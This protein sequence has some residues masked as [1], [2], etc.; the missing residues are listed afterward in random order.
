MIITER[1]NIMKLTVK[2]CAAAALAVTMCAQFTACGKDSIYSAEIDGV[3]VPA[4]VYIYYLQ[5]A[6]YD[7]QDKVGEDTAETDSVADAAAAQTEATTTTADMFYAQSIEGKNVKD[8]IIDTATDYCRTQVAIDKK[9]DEYGLAL[10]D[11]EEQEAEMYCSQMWEYGGSYFTELGIGESSYRSI[12]MNN[13]KRSKL[14][15]K[16]YSAGG[17]YAVS[18]DDLKA[19]L[20]ENFALINYIDI[21]LRDGEGN[22]LKSDGKAERMAMAQEYVD[23]YNAGEDLDA[24]NS[25]YQAFYDGLKAQ[26]EAAA[27]ENAQTETADDSEG[28]AVFNFTEDAVSDNDSDGGAVFNFTEDTVSENNGRPAADEVGEEATAET[29]AE[30]SADEAGEE[31]TAETAAEGSDTE[32]E[33][34]TAI[35]E[36]AEAETTAEE[37]TAAA[38]TA[39]DTVGDITLDTS[40]ATTYSSNLTAIEKDGTTPNA[41]I[42]N[43]AFNNMAIG[44]CKIL[45]SED[46]EHIYVVVKLDILDDESYFEASRQS[47]LYDMREDDFDALIDTWKESQT[48]IRNE[49]AVKRYDPQK[50]FKS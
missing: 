8:W 45:E 12:Y 20:A 4:G 19:H 11:E 32:E 3:Q 40:A 2:K 7:A 36:E 29:E 13:E 37:T 41:Q 23:R 21:E 9:F 14:F 27:A 1:M 26:A 50:I 46:G 47:L 15:E 18:D 24:L 33:Q 31:T 22:L 28:G 39:D 25:E 43:E 5:T 44:D 35:S 49:A 10:T 6:Y 38:E 17:E 16:L 48:V 42:V 34:T 30:T